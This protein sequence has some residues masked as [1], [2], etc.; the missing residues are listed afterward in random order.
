MH[1]RDLSVYFLSDN[2][3]LVVLVTHSE[4][5]V[6]KHSAC[7]LVSHQSTTI[8]ALSHSTELTPEKD[9]AATWL[10]FLL[11]II[12]KL[13]LCNEGYRS[14]STTVSE[15]MRHLSSLRAKHPHNIHHKHS[16]AVWKSFMRKI[17]HLCPLMSNSRKHKLTLML[18]YH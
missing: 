17:T 16:G 9:V 18:Y 2:K 12:N 15:F 14:Y 11:E 10:I 3:G 4:S 1:K 6:W 7:T 5:T 13:A 8:M